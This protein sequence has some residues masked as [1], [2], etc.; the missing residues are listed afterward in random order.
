VQCRAA[1]ENLPSK[2]AADFFQD[3]FGNEDGDDGRDTQGDRI[4][5]PAVDL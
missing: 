2:S 4:A 1:R 5:G 3:V